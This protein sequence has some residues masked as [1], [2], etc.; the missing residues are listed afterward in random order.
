MLKYLP[1]TGRHPE[2]NGKQRALHAT[3]T[4]VILSLISMLL[5]TALDRATAPEGQVNGADEVEL[6][7]FTC[8]DGESLTE[9]N[10]RQFVSHNKENFRNDEFGRAGR[11]RPAKYFTNPRVARRGMRR[12]L[13]QYLEANPEK[14]WVGGQRR[15]V[16]YFWDRAGANNCLGP[17]SWKKFKNRG[18]NGCRFTAP[19]GEPMEYLTRTQF[20]AVG[21][22]AI[23]GSLV[24]LGFFSGGTGWY[25]A[26]GAGACGWGLYWDM[27]R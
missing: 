25:A 6:V 1:F 14:R 20:E 9:C 3:I 11:F 16:Q 18:T 13:N 10:R 17:R 27:A 7:A 19:P 4:L 15:D 22:V 21:T 8:H 26:L 5:F 23:C 24:T 12:A 2:F